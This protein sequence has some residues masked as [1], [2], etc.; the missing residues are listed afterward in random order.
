MKIRVSL[1]SFVAIVA[2]AAVLLTS[3]VANATPMTLFGVAGGQNSA[4]GTVD[5]VT[6]AFSEIGSVGFG[7]ISAMDVDPAT[8]IIYATGIRP[9]A[10]EHVLLTI[11]P[12][13]G[14]GTEVGPTGIDAFGQI[15][16]AGMSFRGDGTLF[17]YLEAGDLVGTI[18]TASGATTEL[19]PSTAD[20][21]GN[22]M[23][24]DASGTTLL[25]ANEDA[26]H[27]VDQTDGQANNLINLDYTSPHFVVADEFPRVAAMDVHPETGE[28]YA[29]VIIGQGFSQGNPAQ[30]YLAILDPSTGTFD[31]RLEGSGVKLD[32]IAFIPEPSTGLLAAFGLIGLILGGSP[33]RP[34]QKTSR[35]K[36]PQVLWGVAD[37]STKKRETSWRLSKRSKA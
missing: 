33:R 26:L 18:D 4:F 10:S 23:A 37:K 6:G 13:T 1:F 24:F 11:D 5:L 28:I 14:Q 34:A 19:G 25:L 27:T 17:G 15:N 21:C 9:W 30:G 7:F 8:G 29:T 31:Y 2:L 36:R 35:I 20:C 3:G 12:S 22:G 16:V 32:A